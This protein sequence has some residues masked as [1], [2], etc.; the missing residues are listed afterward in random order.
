MLSC[1]RHDGEDIVVRVSRDRS[2]FHI[3]QSIHR[4]IRGDVH[5]RVKYAR[6]MRCVDEILWNSFGKSDV[7]I[8]GH[9]FD[10]FL[11]KAAFFAVSD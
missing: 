6:P 1:Y 11:R 4:D 7:I 10:R 3:G 5:A 9:D 8:G 2:F